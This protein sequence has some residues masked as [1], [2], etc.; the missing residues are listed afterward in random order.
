[1]SRIARWWLIMFGLLGLSGCS[2]PGRAPE[3]PA[4]I[5]TATES[6][7]RPTLPPASTPL[8]AESASSHTPAPTVTPTITLTMTP[9]VENF[10]TSTATVTPAITSTW[11]PEVSTWTPGGPGSATDF[12]TPINTPSTSGCIGSPAG[13]NYLFNSGF[14]LG[15]FNQENN[16]SINVPEGWVGFWKPEGTPIEY[17]DEN[18][19]G[20]LRP[21]MLVIR[22]D[23]PF[24]DPLRVH[25]GEQAFYLSGSN[26]V[27]DGGLWQ[28]V[29]VPKGQSFCL[30]GFAHA[31]S[32]HKADDP[33]Q[34]L[35]ETEDDRR[36]ANFLLGIDPTGGTSPW[37]PSVVWGGVG[38]LYDVYQPIPAIQ[39]SAEGETITVFVRGYTMW[40]FDHND[41]FFDDV[42]LI[43]MQQ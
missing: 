28:Q 32:S 11:T 34:S 12:A 30:T 9:T 2:L 33:S 40:R 42:S 13:E 35:L 25:E 21:E 23:P 5:P 16:P 37:S 29:S 18:E 43:P 17:D 36:N 26:K 14:E 4:S 27:F 20:Y 6:R 15:G 24:D 8:P 7:L 31:W 19:D 41:L 10:P 22:A 39:V 1:M 3:L 38:H